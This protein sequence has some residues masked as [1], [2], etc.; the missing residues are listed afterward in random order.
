VDVILDTN[1]LYSP[2]QAQGGNFTSSNA[3]VELVTYLRRTKSDL[4]MP[5]MVVDELCARYEDLLSRAIKQAE[6]ARTTLQHK[7]FTKLINM[8]TVSLATEVRALRERLLNPAQGFQSRQFHDYS[9]V[10]LAEVVRRGIKRIPPAS[11]KGE[12][13]RD[14]VLWLLVLAYAKTTNRDVAFISGDGTFQNQDGAL[15]EQLA[16]DVS[17]AGVKVACYESIRS[18]VAANSLL[19]SSLGEHDLYKI[20]S[21]EQLRRLASKYLFNATIDQGIIVDVQVTEM[22]F[23]KAQQYQVGAN[24]FYIESE[25]AVRARL[26]ILQPNIFLNYAH[27]DPQPITW[28]GSSETFFGSFGG[29]TL[30]PPPPNTVTNALVPPFPTSFRPRS[31]P[32]R[33]SYNATLTMQ[34]SLRVTDGKRESLELDDMIL[35]SKTLIQEPAT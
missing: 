23:R 14:V 27:I 2:L 16:N 31:A 5:Q 7:T 19:S 34:I 15:K 24:S 8:P 13:L 1:I 28:Q 4:V 33:L 35:D 11:S 18:F 17:Q 6:D 21:L 32:T 26:K 9:G 3:F 29:A 25:Y 10:S 12:E 20:V 22:Q 30:Q